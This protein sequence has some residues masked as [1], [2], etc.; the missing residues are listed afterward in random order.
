MTLKELKEILYNYPDM[1]YR[2]GSIKKEIENAKEEV[3]AI[4]E[5]DSV[6][7]DGMPKGKGII[8]DPTY[9][10]ARKIVDKYDKRI[11]ELLTQQE[12]IMDKQ[13]K[14]TDIMRTLTAEEYNII[15]AKYWDGI[16]WDFLPAIVNMS[17]RTCFNV[18]DKAMFKML[19]LLT[20]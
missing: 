2:L 13:N 12:I 20:G 1:T 3:Q 16:K 14:L 6:V 11:K 10:K 17:R 4:R 18:H 15:K 19:Q 9:H 8:S 7:L 5:I